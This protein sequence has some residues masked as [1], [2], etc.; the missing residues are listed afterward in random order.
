MSETAPI[1]QAYAQGFQTLKGLEA[2]AWVDAVRRAGFERFSATGFP[3]KRDERW[4]YTDVKALARGEFPPALTAGERPGELALP[5]PELAGPRLVFIDGVLDIAGS[6]LAALPHGLSVR[7]LDQALADDDDNLAAR[8]QHPNSES[9]GFTALNAALLQLGAVVDVAAGTIVEAP[10]HLVF[11]SVGREDAISVHPHILIHLGTG[12]ALSLVESHI[13]HGENANFVNV[14]SDIALAAN[15]KLTH[16]LFQDIGAS[17]YQVEH[18]NV[19]LARDSRYHAHGINLGGRLLRND[20]DCHLDEPGAEVMLDGLFMAS[21]REHVDNHTTVHH[22]SPHTHSEEYYKGVIDG[23]G[24]GVFDGRVV[25][26]PDAQK[27]EAHQSNPN[28]LLSPHAEIDTKPQLEIYADD[29][30]C[31]HGSTVGQ[32]DSDAL[33]Y[34]RSRGMDAKTA[35]N[36]LIYAFA[37]D[38]IERLPLAELR[39]DLARRTAGRL[40][41]DPNLRGLL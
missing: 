31:S 14:V 11:V 23:R 33:F 13:G 21:S 34:L 20:I 30:K 22:N 39:S 32:L 5:F 10:L 15:A 8:F 18:I 4:R 40:P 29:V 25:V 17:G 26:H 37:E 12:A 27:I 6:N 38:M 7:T 3:G 1:L 24:R 16:C 9:D 28:L 41:G 2:P 35:R 36:L 19:S